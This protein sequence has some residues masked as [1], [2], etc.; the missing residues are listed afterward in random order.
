M[1]PSTGHDDGANDNPKLIEYKDTQG[2]TVFD[3]LGRL[4]M[5]KAFWFCPACKK[6][7]AYGED[8][9]MEC[10]FGKEE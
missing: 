9:I 8:G 10:P 3:W 5:R 1:S 4:F 2:H 7:H 6:L